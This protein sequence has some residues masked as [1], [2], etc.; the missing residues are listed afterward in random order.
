MAEVSKEILDNTYEAL[1]SV[2]QSGKI[3]KGVN[4]TTKSIERGMAMFVAYASDVQP[5]E[6]IAHLP[7]LCEDKKVPFIEVPS[8]LDLGKAIG[9]NVQCSAV[10][11]EN[12]GS[13]ESSLKSIISKITGKSSEKKESQAK[14]AKKEEAKE[15]ASEKKE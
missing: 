1:Q 4:E 8:K 9:L 3:K 6:I 12:A 13:A 11:V 5:A 10:S 2:K 7:K 15:S 14:E